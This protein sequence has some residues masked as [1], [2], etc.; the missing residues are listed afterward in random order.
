MENIIGGNTLL[1][2]NLILK[3]ANIKENITVADLGCGSV[4]YFV[5]PLSKIIGDKGIV[6]AVDI[7]KTA[8]ETIERKKKLENSANIKTIW[9]NLEIFQATSIESGLLDRAFLINTLYLSQKRVEIIRETARMLKKGGI[10]TI[11]EWK[12]IKLPFGPPAEERVDEEALKIGAKKLGLKLEDEFIAGHY[13]YGL[14]F[15]KI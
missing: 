2:I 9:S 12:N 13:H 14:I 6:F 8:L 3:K 5:F 4:G 7:L 1:D 10:L 15:T 11:V